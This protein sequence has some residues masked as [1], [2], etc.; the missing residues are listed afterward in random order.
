MN[1]FTLQSGKKITVTPSQSV[2][3]GGEA[4]VYK[5]DNKTVVKIFKGPDH[6]DILSDPALVQAAA[7]KIK[8]HQNKLISFP[9]GLPN[10][11]VSPEE[12]VFDNNGK[13]IGY[14]MKIVENGEALYSYSDR[15]FQ[16]SSGISVDDVA[17]IFLDLHQTVDLLHKKNVVI[18]DFN[19]L[20]VII[21][22]H[23]AWIIDADSMQFGKFL[24]KMFSQKFV[25]PL[26]CKKDELVLKTTHN[27][28][29]DWFAFAIMLFQ[30]MMFMGPYAGIHKPKSGPKIPAGRRSLERISVFRDDV[31]K[32]KVAN[33]LNDIPKDLQIEFFNIFEKD[34][35]GKFP[36][37]LIEN[38]RKQ[39]AMTAKPHSPVIDQTIQVKGKVSATTIFK[40]PGVILQSNVFDGKICYLFHENGAFKR[41][42]SA[43]VMPGK[44]DSAFH[45]RISKQKT[46]V[47]RR[48]EV[49]VFEGENNNKIPVDMFGN[50][51]VFDANSTHHFWLS[52]GSLYRQDRN[53]LGINQKI[54]DVLKNQTIFWVGEKR[55]FGFYRAGNLT[56]AF[57]FNTTSGNINDN[58]D[59]PDLNG[60]LID[61][62]CIFVE[63]KYIYFMVKTK[64]K[65]KIKNRCFVY[66]H[67]GKIIEK[68][69]VD[70][71]D[72][73]WLGE[74]RGKTAIGNMLFSPT[75]DGI[76][77]TDMDS[78]RL[79][80]TH[81]YSD[82]AQWVNSG[83]R[84][85]MLADGILVVS[86]KQI[87][88][89]QIGT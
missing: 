59:I 68:L 35:R 29:S 10:H 39:P 83:S 58:I 2:G 20:N 43:T 61:S 7:D 66:D 18:G 30:S 5:I 4:D 34:K 19:D 74:I 79:S 28:N 49:I 38:L 32:P 52:E 25:D 31:I 24:C 44:L 33:N 55:G 45:Y 42:G 12:V 41:E 62:T 9:K 57:L 67:V 87:T 22:N 6:Q 80:S 51:S 21:N 46:L 77:R 47:G 76:M 72:Q 17:K 37:L 81:L 63:D 48:G 26:L 73:H 23:G 86:G 85:H 36:I 65:A 53:R 13:I 8:E 54:G 16:Q 3:K 56:T 1:N 70:D 84:L 60:N 82:T 71:G 27:K 50:L 11:V 15:K 89:L 64:I 75:D 78:G 40:T 14:T 69:E 88:K